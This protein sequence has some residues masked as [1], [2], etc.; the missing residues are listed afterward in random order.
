MPPDVTFGVSSMKR[1]IWNLH[2]HDY[3]G[4]QGNPAFSMSTQI[5]TAMIRNDAEL[6][7]ERQI[8]IRKHDDCLYP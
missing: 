3:F 1:S 2:L 7:K 4:G 5:F 6:K 8:I